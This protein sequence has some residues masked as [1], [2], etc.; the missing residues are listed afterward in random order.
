LEDNIRV[1]VF[2]HCG[3]SGGEPLPDDLARSC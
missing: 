1:E 3:N 2:K